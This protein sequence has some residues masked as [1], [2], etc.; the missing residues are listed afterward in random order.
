MSQKAP[1]PVLKPLNKLYHIVSHPYTFLL[2]LVILVGWFVG[3]YVMHFSEEWYKY[4]HIFEITVALIMVFLIEHTTHAD[5]RA[6]QEKLDEIIKTMPRA[7]NAKV[8]L[9]QKYKGGK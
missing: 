5:N 3:G 8:G 1:T 7:D 4:F 9:E 2:I 6:M